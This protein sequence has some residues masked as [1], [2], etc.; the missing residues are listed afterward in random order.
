MATPW[1]FLDLDEDAKELRRHTL[2]R[3]AGYAQ[4]SAFGPVFLVLIHRL[5]FWAIK[6]FDA[7]R[8]AYSAV[9]ES[10]RR[11]IRRQSPLGAWEARYQ[12]FQWWFGGDVVFFGQ[13]WGR[14]DEWAFGLAWGAWMGVL[15][16]LETGG[17]ELPY[18][19]LLKEG[20]LE[21]DMFQTIFISQKG[22]E[23]S[24]FLRFLSSIF[25]L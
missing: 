22:L 23:S 2:D 6:S 17:G 16:V 9:P 18:M 3:Y 8:G 4:I 19:Q 12:Q 21:A 7:R 20:H 5:A 24:E 25:L 10:P 13:S 15:S 11:K 14:R 1:K